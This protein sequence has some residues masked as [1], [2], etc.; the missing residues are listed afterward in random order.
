MK[1]WSVAAVM[2]KNEAVTVKI[3]G[4]RVVDD[5]DGNDD[6]TGNI[7]GGWANGGQGW[8]QRACSQVYGGL[9]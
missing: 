7:G 2:M 8:R 5:L 6:G 9:G 1:I 4:E 3:D